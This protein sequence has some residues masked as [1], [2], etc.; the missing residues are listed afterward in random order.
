MALGVPMRALGEGVEEGVRWGERVRQ[1]VEVR[2]ESLLAVGRAVLLPP[3]PH[4]PALALPLSD[5]AGVGV[6]CTVGEGHTTVL[7]GLTVPAGVSVPSV[8]VAVAPPGPGECV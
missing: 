4:A 8:G 5:A 1:A 3:F 7:V 6:T 2:V